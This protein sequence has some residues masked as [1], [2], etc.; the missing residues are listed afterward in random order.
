[1]AYTKNL[2]ARSRP[3]ARRFTSARRMRDTVIEANIAGS[4][5]G[6]ADLLSLAFRSTLSALR[7]DA[8]ASEPKA[9]PSDAVGATDETE[10]NAR[11]RPGDTEP[12]KRVGGFN[13]FPAFRRTGRANDA[14]RDDANPPNVSDE[15]PSRRASLFLVDEAP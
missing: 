1:M 10:G 5:A 2:A 9:S 13:A 8:F 15:K 14:T 3:G 11:L 7:L 4:G 6:D 12:R